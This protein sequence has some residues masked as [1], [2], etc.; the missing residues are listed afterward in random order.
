MAVWLAPPAS[1]RTAPAEV[2]IWLASLTATPGSLRSCWEILD[3]NERARALAFRFPRPRERFVIARG[4]LRQILGRYFRQP[5][6]SLRLATEAHGKPFLA[7]NVLDLRFNIA[8]S[9]DLA[10]VAVSQAREVGVDVE[11]VRE[12][13]EVEAIA[14]HSF[15]RVEVDALLKLPPP[16]RGGAFFA[17]WTL[18]E[19]Y[20]KARG[21]GLT[22]PLDAFAVSVGTPGPARLLD[23]R[24]T[25]EE[26]PRWSLRTLPLDGP[27][28]AAVA[29]EG[30]DWSLRRWRWTS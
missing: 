2:H 4:I 1:P 20:L 17:C 22:L 13:L 8:H 26:A 15:S 18:K 14:R 25:P 7:D 30:H 16:L 12:H 21:D 9:E 11:R 24:G 10:L 23:V 3:E 19:A 6:A 29:V 5:P 27:Y 28:R